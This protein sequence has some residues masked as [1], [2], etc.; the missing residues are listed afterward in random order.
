MAGDRSLKTKTDTLSAGQRQEAGDAGF[1][2]ESKLTLRGRSAC[3]LLELL[4][5]ATG[6]S[7]L[8]LFGWKDPSEIASWLTGLV[9]WMLAGLAILILAG[10]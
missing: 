3:L 1:C 9:L 7:V 10:L 6:S 5:Y 8:Q 4:F 2:E